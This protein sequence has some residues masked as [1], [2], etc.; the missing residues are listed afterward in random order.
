M[1]SNTDSALP[2]YR[3]L[4]SLRLILNEMRRLEW[5]LPRAA[6]MS[7]EAPPADAFLEYF[8][9]LLVNLTRR[10]ASASGPHLTDTI[11]QALLPAGVERP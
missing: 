7:G 3:Q 4:M 10:Q 2:Y 5:L 9:P 1:S 11:A 6:K 8:N